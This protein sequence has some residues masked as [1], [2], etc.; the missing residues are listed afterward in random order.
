V[1]RVHAARQHEK[2]GDLRLII[3]TGHAVSTTITRFLIIDGNARVLPRKRTAAP[4]GEKSA[5]AGA[6]RG[7][8]GGEGGG[9]G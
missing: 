4:C 2:D 1:V 3:Q 7:A 6:G 8:R 5:E 9:E